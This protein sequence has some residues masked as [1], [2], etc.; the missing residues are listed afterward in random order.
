MKTI[1]VSISVLMIGFIFSGCATIVHGSRQNINFSSVPSAAKIYID[2]KDVG[3]TP[4]LISL[5]RNGKLNGQPSGKQF[6]DIKITID[7]YMPYEMKILRKGDGWVWG[8][9]AFGGLIGLIIDA[10]DGA[11]YNLTPYQINAQIS[12]NTSWNK[13]EKDNIYIAAT[14][15]PDPSWQKIG[16]LEKK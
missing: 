6:Y 10:A 3:V 7:G 12:K 1:I 15:I 14:L 9:L 5:R 11:M 13:I 8:N 2:N 4:K 16:V